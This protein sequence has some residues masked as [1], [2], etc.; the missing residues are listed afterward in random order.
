MEKSASDATWAL[1]AEGVAD[2]RLCVHG[3]G[4][5]LTKFS[6]VCQNQQHKEL[7]AKLFGDLIQA[8]PESIQKAERALDRTGYA[9]SKIGEDHIKERLSLEDRAKVEQG[10]QSMPHARR[11]A[12]L[13]ERYLNEG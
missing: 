13:V 7:L 11:K 4:Q 2:A 3:V 5:M 1:L 8:L 10:L 6:K 12:L 9:L